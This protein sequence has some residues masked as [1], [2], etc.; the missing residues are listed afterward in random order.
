MLLSFGHSFLRQVSFL[1]YLDW[2]IIFQDYFV[3]L[4]N[5][6]LWLIREEILI[7][8]CLSEKKKTHHSGNVLTYSRL[9]GSSVARVVFIYS[10]S[11]FWTLHV[12]SVF[13]ES[14]CVVDVFVYL[15]TNILIATFYFSPFFSN[16]YM[17]YFLCWFVLPEFSILYRGSEVSLDLYPPNNT[18]SQNFLTCQMSKCKHRGL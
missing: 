16:V 1:L 6:K 13:E 8:F 9:F 10:C 15:V 12:F 17:I 5:W 7:I 11:Y 14:H 4:V 2:Y 18:I 3:T